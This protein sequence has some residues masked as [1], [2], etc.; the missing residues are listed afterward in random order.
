MGRSKEKKKE[1]SV[2]GGFFECCYYPLLLSYIIIKYKTVK[3]LKKS[4]L[5][6]M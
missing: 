5:R 6:K 3:P 2:V 1:I 4:F